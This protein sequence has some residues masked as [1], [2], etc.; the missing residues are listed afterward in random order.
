MSPRVRFGICL[1]LS[2]CTLS[3]PVLADAPRG[4]AAASPSG[5]EA[6]TEHVRRGDKAR[7]AGRWADAAAA[8]LEAITAA[9]RFGLTDEKRAAIIGEFG[10]CELAMGKYRDAAEHL[11]VAL[12]KFDGLPPAQR[13]RFLQGQRKAESEVV[14]VFVGLDPPDAEL[15]VDGK[16]HAPRWYL[17]AGA[18]GGAE[19]LNSDPEGTQHQS[20][21]KR[22]TPRLCRGGNRSLT[23][24]GVLKAN[25]PP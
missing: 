13:Q 17:S 9:E 8:Y 12:R 15:S 18:P 16:P 11:H 19:L 7:N 25:S 3:A 10:M 2:V 23:N 6:V 20:S 1:V 24:P 4:T 22:E 14:V 21:V 5:E